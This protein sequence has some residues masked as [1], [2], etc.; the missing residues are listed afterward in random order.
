MIW[1]I[2]SFFEISASCDVYEES[3]SFKGEEDTTAA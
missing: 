3:R 1:L 2:S